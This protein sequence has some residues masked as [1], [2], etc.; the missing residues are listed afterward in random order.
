[1]M[2]P[3]CGLVLKMTSQQLDKFIEVLG[4]SYVLATELLIPGPREASLNLK[5]ETNMFATSPAV[6][7]SWSSSLQSSLGGASR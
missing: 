4:I 2:Q 3:P 6:R 1:M 7:R 5:N